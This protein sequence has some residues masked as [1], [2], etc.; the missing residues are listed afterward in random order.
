MALA[1]AFCIVVI[2]NA[3]VLHGD[4]GGPMAHGLRVFWGLQP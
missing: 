1:A 4:L 3:V 2:L